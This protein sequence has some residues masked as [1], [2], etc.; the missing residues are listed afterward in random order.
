M[1]DCTDRRGCLGSVL[2]GVVLLCFGDIIK[3]FG[4]R[5]R[6]CGGRATVAAAVCA[7]REGLDHC[8]LVGVLFSVDVDREPLP[9]VGPPACALLILGPRDRFPVGA[10]K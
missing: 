8:C 6:K 4:T 1:A 2:S 10:A 7:F 3:R 5:L 9:E